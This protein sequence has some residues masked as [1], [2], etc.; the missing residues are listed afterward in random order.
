MNLLYVV[1]KRSHLGRWTP[2]RLYTIEPTKLDEPCVHCI[3]IVYLYTWV[4]MWNV[5]FEHLCDIFFVA[6]N[7]KQAYKDVWMQQDCRDQH[8]AD[9]Q[10]MG[11]SGN[12]MGSQSTGMMAEV[13]VFL[14]SIYF[15]DYQP[16]H[17]F[18][19]LGSWIQFGGWGNLVKHKLYKLHI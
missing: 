18:S 16:Q 1:H 10:G 8:K 6:K 4:F 2:C 14:Q 3:N 19:T 9:N 11:W 12:F 7:I 17:S 15:D 5:Y 13:S